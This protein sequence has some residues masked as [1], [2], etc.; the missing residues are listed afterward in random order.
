MSGSGTSYMLPLF[1][2]SL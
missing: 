2:I 1:S